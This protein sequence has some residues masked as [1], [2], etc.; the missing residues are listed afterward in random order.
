MD[1]NLTFSEKHGYMPPEPE[2]AIRHEAP[3]WLREIVVRLAYEANLKPSDSRSILCELLVE[4][5]DRNNFSE[6]P[7]IDGEVSSLLADAAWFHVYDFIERIADKILQPGIR[8]NFMAGETN[9]N[10]DRFTEKLNLTFRRKGVGWQLVNRRIQIRGPESF[11]V[12]VRQS[13]EALHATGRQVAAREIHEALADL[14][15]RPAPDITG[16][17]Q[18]AM[19]AL[20]CVARVVAGNPKATLGELL[21]QHPDLLPPPLDTALS[22]IWGFASE[23]GR[24][25]IEARAPEIKEAELVVGLAGSLVTYLVKKFALDPRLKK[26][27]SKL[28]SPA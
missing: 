27:S 9:P 18:H 20:E 19:A 25:L 24:H 16:A 28:P 8:Y 2:I 21:K 22:K 14:S 26:R 15:R 6:F 4:A 7:N 11:E 3:A 1:P 23:Q 17:I 10:L 13:K 12:A 5:P